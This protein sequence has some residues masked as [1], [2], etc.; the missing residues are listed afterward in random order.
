MSYRTNANLLSSRASAVAVMAWS[1]ALLD[2][3]PYASD[4]PGW[5]WTTAGLILC[6]GSILAYL[7]LQ[8]SQSQKD[9]SK[10]VVLDKMSHLVASNF[11]WSTVF[12]SICSTQLTLMLPLG[13][14]CDACVQQNRSLG[15]AIGTAVLLSISSKRTQISEL[16]IVY[17][18]LYFVFT[19]VLSFALVRAK[20]QTIP[21]L[22]KLATHIETDLRVVGSYVELDLYRIVPEV[23]ELV[24]F[25]DD[26]LLLG[27]VW[28]GG[29]YS[30][31][32]TVLCPLLR[33]VVG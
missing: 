8:V 2:S 18:W 20:S 14:L 10:R 33:L 17:A 16:D 15:S 27:L 26:L 23:R 13:L 31:M 32:A 29:R 6:G 28:M 12:L 25:V 22:D 9:P 4:G 7:V 3:N 30:I 21:H 19:V 5:A 11:G 1:A 24:S